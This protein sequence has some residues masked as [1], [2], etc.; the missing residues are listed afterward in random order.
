MLNDDPAQSNPSPEP[1][2]VQPSPSSSSASLNEI[3]SGEG[4]GSNVP[5]VLVLILVVVVFL[6]GGFF[7]YNMYLTP[8]EKSD[9]GVIDQDITPTITE[10]PRQ[11]TDKDDVM[12]LQE[13]LDST[14]VEDTS[15]SDSATLDADINQL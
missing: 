13:E 14:K 6:V 4:K 7:L 10:E 2:V 1:E 3:V 5:M 15:N 11:I 9:S 12:T 8:S